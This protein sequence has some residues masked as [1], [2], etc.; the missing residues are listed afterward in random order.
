[1]DTSIKTIVLD[2]T[3]AESINKVEEIQSLWSGY[4]SILRCTLNKA[5]YQSIVLKHIKRPK[6]NH[7]PHGWNTNLSHQRKLK[8]YHIEKA[9]YKLWSQH[10]DDYCYVPDC[11]FAKEMDAE[12]II[13]L[14]DLKAS[15]FSEIRHSVQLSDIKLCLN[16]LANFH[17]C[18]INKTPTELWKTGTYWHLETRPD[19]LEALN[20][21][22]LKDAASQID[23]CLN[24]CKFKTFV[25]GDAKLANFCFT[26]NSKKVAAVD[27][28]YV[29]GG[30]GMKDVAYFIG[31]C[32]SEKE[33]EKL[34]KELLNY[35]F[36][37]L[38]I[39]L[40]RKRSTINFQ[41]LETEWRTLFPVAWADF[42][43]FLKGWSPEHW[44]LNSYSEKLTKQVISQ[45]KSSHFDT[46]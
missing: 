33:C 14:E 24:Q 28:Q 2:I 19:E 7:H 34:E 41:E 22:I 44:K 38:E 25:H 21:V 10:C 1:M 6:S 32:L 40:T 4:G 35:Y 23:Q 42:H 12:S 8:S 26:P 46:K 5:K 45:L 17:A 30:C 31:S 43:R 29:G 9:F 13:I 15:G 16:W 18:F 39:A 37:A 36:K 27:F 20:D 3:Q 11:Y